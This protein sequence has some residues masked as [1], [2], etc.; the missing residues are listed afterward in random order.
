MAENCF[1]SPISAT[2]NEL[3]EVNWGIVSTTSGTCISACCILNLTLVFAEL[4]GLDCIAFPT[5]AFLHSTTGVYGFANC[6]TSIDSCPT[7][8]DYNCNNE[9]CEEQTLS[10]DAVCAACPPEYAPMFH[11]PISKRFKCGRMLGSNGAIQSDESEIVCR[12]QTVNQYPLHGETPIPVSCTTK[13]WIEDS[14]YVS[15]IKD[16]S[17]KF[18]FKVVMKCHMLKVAI[19]QF[20]PHEASWHV[21]CR[22]QSVRPMIPWMI[23]GLL[24]I[25]V[26]GHLRFFK[27]HLHCMYAY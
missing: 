11:D 27:H 13:G 8:T 3:V 12:P 22:D 2:S 18:Q 21:F 25:V 10:E 26:L 9:K 24:A 20:L 14:T 5:S 6:S 7:A 16:D 23:Q 1:A 4:V 15:H 19:T 17:I